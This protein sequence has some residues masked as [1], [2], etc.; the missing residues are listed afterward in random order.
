MISHLP[1]MLPVGMGVALSRTRRG[2]A[3]AALASAVTAR[4]A[5]GV[6]HETLNLAAVWRAPLVV[7]VERNRYAYMTPERTYLP[8]AEIAARAAGYGIAR[9]AVDGNDVAEVYAIVRDARSHHARSGNGPALIEAFTYRMH[10]HGAHDDQSTCPGTS[11]RHGRA[12]DPLALARAARRS[13]LAWTPADQADLEERVDARSAEALEEALAAPYPAID[14]LGRERLRAMTGPSPTSRRSGWRSTGAQRR[15]PGRRP[16]RGRRCG[17]RRL[18]GHRGAAGRVRARACHRHAD[19]RGGFH[20]RR[21]R[22]GARRDASRCRV[23]VQRLPHERHERD[24][25]YR[26]EDALPPRTSACRS[27]FARPRGRLR[28]R[29]FHSQNPEAWFLRTPGP[30]G[31]VRR[32]PPRMPASCSGAAI[33]DPNPV[34]FFEQKSLYTRVKGAF[35]YDDRAAL[36]A[37]RV[38]RPGADVTVR[39]L[40]SGSASRARGGRRAR[41]RRRRLRGDRSASALP[42]RLGRPSPAPIAKRAGA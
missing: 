25:Q 16:G 19:Q 10:G 40:R 28:R 32:R 18:P 3:S 12:R 5:G 42:A 27:S 21:S 41:R 7:V 13:E 1:E 17:R 35:A 4:R 15:R 22:N 14:D 37:P 6:F 33:A 31:R 30:Q 23:P 20:R 39:H 8:V 36:S 11:S 34:M 38:R 24:R 9:G 2:E 26:R 29:P